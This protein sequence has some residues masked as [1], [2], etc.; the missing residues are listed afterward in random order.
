MQTN[1]EPMFH[2]FQH[3]EMMLMYKRMDYFVIYKLVTVVNALPETL[4]N[5]R[6]F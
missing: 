5:V 3:F 1:K 2:C 4:D 6:R